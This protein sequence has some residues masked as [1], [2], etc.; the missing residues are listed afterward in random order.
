MTNS[1]L[2]LLL[3]LGVVRSLGYTVPQKKAYKSALLG[4]RPNLRGGEVTGFPQSFAVDFP[5]TT[6]ITKVELVKTPKE[7]FEALVEKGVATSKM[8]VAKV[9]HASIMGGCYVGIGGLL[10]LMIAGNCPG[11][12]Q[13]NPGLQKFIFAALFPVN[14]LLVLQTG[15]QLF[16]GNTATMS[17]ALCEMRITLPQLLRSWGLSFVGNVIGCGALA[18]AAQY[19]GLLTSGAAE[20][21]VAMSLKKCGGSFG[22]TL[23]KA[24]LCNWLV[25]LAV[26]LATSAHDLAGK[27][28]GIW[29]PISTFV[30]IG[31]EHSVANLFLLPLALLAGAP[32]T[33]S[34]V[35]LKNLVPA[36]IGNAIAGSL[37]IGAGLSFAHGKLGEGL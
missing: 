11:I 14:L 8:S 32:L 19:T 12:A 37:I 21:A 4:N 2:K 34:D 18:L 16:T 22:P 23:V 24:I 30:A 29:L 28:V 27:M 15:S 7:T 26:F 33:V 3:V 6:G 20:L 9:M 5:V 35:L 17:A 1:L 31:L 10:S 13:A 25:C 36:V